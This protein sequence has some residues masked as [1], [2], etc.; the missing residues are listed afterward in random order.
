MDVKVT[1]G[2]L[3]GISPS[4]AGGVGKRRFPGGNDIEERLEGTYQGM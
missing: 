4:L 3:R 2:A 1:L